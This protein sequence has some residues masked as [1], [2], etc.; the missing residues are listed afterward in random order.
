MSKGN[1]F[2]IMTIFVAGMIFSP[3]AALSYP[4]DDDDYLDV[5][6]AI[7]DIDKNIIKDIVFKTRGDIPQEGSD[8][9]F[10]YGVVTLANNTLNVIATTS[11]PK[12]G[13]IDSELQ[14]SP[15]DP[16]F[17]NHYVILGNN[18]ICGDNPAVQDLSFTSPGKVII[19][20]NK[21]ILKDLPASAQGQFT[22]VTVTPGTN[23]LI[24]ASFLLESHFNQTTNQLQAVCV[25]DIKPVEPQDK[26]TLI[27]GQT[28]KDYYNEQPRNDDYYN[29]QPRNDDYYNEQPR[30]DDYYNEQ[31]R[32]DDYY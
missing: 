17:H 25:V 6:K 21:A 13:I 4:D 23:V 8:K 26:R 7:I 32:N 3:L 28:E 29:E 15:K 10:G 18:S 24:V 5:Q 20:G 12:L 27:I 19:D 30:N 2:A 16:V 22:N 9:N 11:H 14:K 31:P 1:I